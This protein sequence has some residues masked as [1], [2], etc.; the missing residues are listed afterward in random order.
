[1]REFPKISS[2]TDFYLHKIDSKFLLSGSKELNG[3]NLFVAVLDDTPTSSLPAHQKITEF[4]I[5]LN[6]ASENIN[7]A[8]DELQKEVNLTI[9][10][11]LGNIV[12]SFS[13]LNINAAS[14]EL[15]NLSPGSYYLIINNGKSISNV[16]PLIIR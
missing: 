13:F 4:E 10:S 14:L 8:F 6:L 7:I 12:K 16:K 2:R 3:L 11:S 1:R 15:A 5:F 9:Y